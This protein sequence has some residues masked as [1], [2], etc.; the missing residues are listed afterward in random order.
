MYI[1]L[2]SAH[3]RSQGTV[4]ASAGGEGEL[5]LAPPLTRNIHVQT[6]FRDSETQTD[7]YTP[8]YIIGPGSQPELLTLATLC[9]G[10]GLPAGQA[11]VEMIERA[12]AKRVW[13]AGL[14]P[15]DDVVQLGKRR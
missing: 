2:S 5:S 8:E 3:Y 6:D 14:P 15:V 4:A 11:Q 13:E 7:P 9:Y 12:R 1:I 10:N